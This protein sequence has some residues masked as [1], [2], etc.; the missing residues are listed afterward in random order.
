MRESILSDPTDDTFLVHAQ[1]D[2]VE[3]RLRL[4]AVSSHPQF[5]TFNRFIVRLNVLYDPED[6][7]LIGAIKPISTVIT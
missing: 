5:E 4:L 7:G 2:R 6:A 3:V 1:L